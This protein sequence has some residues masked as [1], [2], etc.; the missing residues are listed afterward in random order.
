VSPL[1]ERARLREIAVAQHAG[2]MKE[3]GL[4][5]LRVRGGGLPGTLGRRCLQERK[6]SPP[7]HYV[8]IICLPALI[9]LRTMSIVSLKRRRDAAVQRCGI[10]VSAGALGCA[11]MKSF[12]DGPDRDVAIDAL[13]LARE[14]GIDFFDSSNAYGRAATR[15]W[16]A[17]ATST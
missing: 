17:I 5:S 13:R 2:A 14:I 12:Y 15:N 4:P 10:E 6:S 16:R 3:L 8:R 1:P 7:S 9:M 11:T